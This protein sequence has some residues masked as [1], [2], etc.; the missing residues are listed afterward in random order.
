MFLRHPSGSNFSRVLLWHMADVETVWSKNT[1][2]VFVVT[3]LWLADKLERF[4]ENT[5][6]ND[7]LSVIVQHA[8][9]MHVAVQLLVLRSS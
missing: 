1:N 4:T 8:M 6:A 5:I 7:R 9:H 3:M 2:S